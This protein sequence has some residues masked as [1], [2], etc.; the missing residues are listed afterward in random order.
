MAV[1]ETERY[2][3][4]CIDG[5]PDPSLNPHFI[6]HQTAV[7]HLLGQFASGK[8]HHAWLIT[9][10]KGIG[11]AT[12]ALRFAAHV[13]RNPSA[14]AENRNYDNILVQDEIS[15]RI[16]QGGHPNL[17]HLSRP[18]DFDKKKFKTKLTVEEIRRTVGFFGTSAGESG[19]RVC[20][21]DAIDDMNTNASNALLKI[22]EEP[23]SNTIFLVLAHSGAGVLP[24]VRSRCQT[25][26]M[27]PLPPNFLIDALKA[28][29]AIDNI[30]A[31]QH[32]LLCDLAEGSVRRGL[33]LAQNNGM[34]LH[35][36]FTQTLNIGGALN[37]TK[38][39]KLAES[40]CRKGNEDR[41][42]LL[43]DIIIR[44]IE[45][46]ATGKS[47]AS[48]DLSSLVQWTDVWEKVRKSRQLV[49]SYNLDKK[50][51]ILN[52]FEEMRQAAQTTN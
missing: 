47:G 29:G 18:W 42:N 25:L 32:D 1:L 9:G 49:N 28:L 35:Q 14:A 7:E 20:L 3:V 24:T 5:I 11:K 48:S 52:M 39:H 19:W 43:F 31:D 33:V 17:L 6:G 41:Y 21:V 50:Q 36:E 8:M 13:F 23:P 12:M 10:P 16:A 45:G 38:V 46:K 27:K 22:L 30:P 2:L 44:D 15:S 4:D 37:W 51:A 40:V 26:S 34:E